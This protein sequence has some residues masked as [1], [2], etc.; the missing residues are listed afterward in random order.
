MNKGS[1]AI[2]KVD[3]FN[4]SILECKFRDVLTALGAEK[5]FNLS[6]LE[7]KS[8][9]CTRYAAK[10]GVLIYPYW[11]VN[12]CLDSITELAAAVLIYPY[13]NVNY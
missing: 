6:I 2:I 9:N 4:L 11:N 10:K 7:C 13:W 8:K 5:S 1:Y 12:F 3:R